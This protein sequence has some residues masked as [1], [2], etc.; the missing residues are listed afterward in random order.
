MLHFILESARFCNKEITDCI[1]AVTAKELVECIREDGG[2]MIKLPPIQRSAVWTNAQIINFWDSLL[3]GYPAGMMFINKSNPEGKSRSI[4][5]NSTNNNINKSY[6]LFDGQQRVN[7]I[8]LAYNEGFSSKT[9]RLWIDFSRE[10]SELSGLKFQ[11]R[12]SSV[13]QPFGY[14][15]NNP[16]QKAE[17]SLRSKK[18]VEWEESHNE[19]NSVRDAFTKTISGEGLIHGSCDVIQFSDVINQNA[20]KINQLSVTARERYEAFKGKLEQA[21][22]SKVIFFD[23]SGYDEIVSNPEEYVRFFDRL[24]R[25]GT[26]L[27]ERELS[28]SIL[29]QSFPDVHDNIRKIMDSGNGLKGM[30]GELELALGS[31][32]V[33]KFF[34]ARETG[35]KNEGVGPISS[36]QVSELAEQGSEIRKHFLLQ[37]PEVDHESGILYKATHEIKK[38]LLLTDTDPCGFPSILLAETP[39]GLFDV[40]L[41]LL[42][43]EESS[44]NFFCENTDV[45]KA[46]C[47]FWLLFVNNDVKASSIV[48]ENILD[49]AIEKRPIIVE[50]NLLRELIGLLIDRDVTRKVP[51]KNDIL[52]TTIWLKQDFNDD[53]DFCLRSWND[54][55]KVNVNGKELDNEKMETLRIVTTNKTLI[56]RLLMWTQRVYINSKFKNYDPTSDRD[57]DLP[58]DLD[59]LVPQ[60]K[61]GFNWGS[62]HQQLVLD[63][64]D[65]QQKKNIQNKFRY[66]REFIGNSLGNFRWLASSDNRSRQDGIIVKSNNDRT[67]DLWF[68]FNTEVESKCAIKDFNSIISER[69]WTS[70]DVKEMQRVIDL[71]SV[72]IFEQAASFIRENLFD[73][74]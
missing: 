12:M 4:R 71:R 52:E 22:S 53:A 10:P 74:K 39:S 57:E 44:C 45:I 32:R 47:L 51:D 24:G 55:F 40:L 58:M 60:S 67:D 36:K 42:S 61:F 70:E 23:I 29:K 56:K 35:N 54:R 5:D 6:D 20:E 59:H 27:S 31:A 69:Q 50:E 48:Y 18:W 2:N 66:Q 64:N 63:E 65:S 33:A 41:L 7:A 34:S 21:L 49:K 72:F 17:L 3:R 25:G 68:N 13:G 11:L 14:D 37:L 26:A 46:F 8:L 15:L 1:T 43:T 73:I 28:Y 9:R 16:N 30:I 62:R 38:S 19:E